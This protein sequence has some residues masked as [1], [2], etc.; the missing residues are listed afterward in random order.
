MKSFRPPLIAAL[1]IALAA[2]ALAQR[3]RRGGGGR[4][5]DSIRT[6]REVDSHSTGT[7]TW[8]NPPAFKNDV[9]TFARIRYDRGGWGRGGGWATDL[10][11]SD[12]NL[13]FRLQ[14]MTSMRVDPDGRILSLTDPELADFPFIYI[15][16]PGALTFSDA[17]VEALRAYLLNGGFLM[18]DDFWGEEAWENV[19]SEMKRVFPGKPFVELAL[20]HPLYQKPFLIKEKGQVPAIDQGVASQ[21]SGVTWERYDAQE[22][23]HRG[24]S[25][26]K[27]RLMVLACHNTD[28]G[29]GWEREGESDYYFHNFSEK[30]AYPLGIN[31]V[32]YVMTH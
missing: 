13:S 18:F 30:I 15:V 4:E 5:Y 23:H 26:D 8:T 31:I 6:A 12:L 17:E 22:V 3:W 16:E 11:D 25:D 27:E 20:D 1:L 32:F 24:I 10:P 9:F 2:G 14:Q 21:Y 29:D 19:E 28:N 7:P